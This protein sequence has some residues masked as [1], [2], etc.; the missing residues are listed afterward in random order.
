MDPR[1]I[2]FIQ[3]TKTKD[4]YTLRDNI[5]EK[6]EKDIPLMELRILM[7][8]NLAGEGV[9]EEV[10]RIEEKREDTEQEDFIDDMGLD[11]P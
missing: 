9:K 6:F 3:K 4:A 2:N 10:K 1:I 8:S 11:G 7:K 5:I